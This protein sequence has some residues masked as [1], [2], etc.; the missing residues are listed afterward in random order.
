MRSKV[1]KHTRLGGAR[2]SADSLDDVISV[3]IRV[4]FH[5]YTLSRKEALQALA[6]VGSG[7]EEKTLRV[8]D[9]GMDC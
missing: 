5:N 1:L 8:A 2:C 3:G 4:Y 7:I 9:H 6:L